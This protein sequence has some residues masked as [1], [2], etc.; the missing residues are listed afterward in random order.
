[1]ALSDRFAVGWDG[2]TPFCTE[3]LPRWILAYDEPDFLD[4]RPLLELFFTG[5]RFW[6]HTET[7]EIDELVDAVAGGVAVGVGSVLVLW[8]SDF[9]LGGDTNV[10]LLEA[11]GQDVDVGL[12]HHGWSM[13]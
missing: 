11:T 10:E 5:D 2:F 6:E 9:N 8:C 7:F 4:A 1:M 3:V 12:I 13:E